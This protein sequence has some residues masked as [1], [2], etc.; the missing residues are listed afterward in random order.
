VVDPLLLV[1]HASSSDRHDRRPS[2]GLRLRLP[3]STLR[4]GW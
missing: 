4:G 3:R 1:R 2:Q